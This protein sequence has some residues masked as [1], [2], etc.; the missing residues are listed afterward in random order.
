MKLSTLD[1]L[2]LVTPYL[3]DSLVSPSAVVAIGELAALLPPSSNFGFECRLGTAASEADFLVAVIPTD[4][5]LGAW[6]GANPLAVALD[7]QPATPGWQKARDFFADWQRGFEEMKPI[8]EAWLEFDTADGKGSG[9]LEPSFFFGFDPDQKTNHP[10][11]T[12]ALLE[13][14][15]E[16][17][18]S[19]ERRQELLAYFSALPPQ[20]VI[21][22][23][24]VMLS[25]PSSEI[26][27]CLRHMSP[28]EVLAYLDYFGW[29]GSLEELE[30]LMTELMARVD[31][32]LNLDIS[33]QG[34]GIA[35]GIGLEIGR[36]D[37]RGGRA[38][39][40]A[41]MSY[42]IS[43]KICL[44]EK[45]RAILHWVGFSSEQTEGDRWPALLTKAA[46][47]MGPGVVSTF[48]RT[49][50]HFK[51]SYQKGQPV[52]AK[53]YLGGRHFWAQVV[54]GGA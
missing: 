44:E 50:N 40:T 51:I 8:N 39:A 36:W 49:L 46:R 5:S 47:A 4:G 7:A 27:F 6:A 48:G 26:R 32:P 17:G 1:Y 38:R 54:K 28:Q 30:K 15:V 14:L 12:L 42:L 52:S 43:E 24:G 29:P 21:F 35:P 16:G 34:G 33:L 20:A 13:R 41:F 37:S 22:Q 10:E 53:A 2:N 31:A 9:P 19:A 25:R 23:V 45:A 18:L 3:P 11:L